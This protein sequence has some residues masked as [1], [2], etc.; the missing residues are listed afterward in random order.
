MSCYINCHYLIGWLLAIYPKTNVVIAILQGATI[1]LSCYGVPANLPCCDI[2]LWTHLIS[3]LWYI[4]FFYDV[5]DVKVCRNVPCYECF[6][7]TDLGMNG[8]MSQITIYRSFVKEYV[9]SSRWHALV[10]YYFTSFPFTPPDL[11]T[12]THR[13]FNKLMW[14]C[15]ISK[16]NPFNEFRK[17]VIWIFPQFAPKWQVYDMSLFHTGWCGTGGMPLP[18]PT[19]TL[20]TPP[21]P[22]HIYIYIYTTAQCVDTAVVLYMFMDFSAVYKQLV[23]CLTMDLNNMSL[24]ADYWNFN[25]MITEGISDFRGSKRDDD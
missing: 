13:V 5:D 8:I 21:P 24:I 19:I 3:L 16:G 1:D 9:P 23:F 2:L 10:C 6:E 17:I 25:V 22:P 11:K 12:S 20:F 14:L 4:C 18:E 7:N 15:S